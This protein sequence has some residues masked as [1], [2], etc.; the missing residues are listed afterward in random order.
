M[1][2]QRG[3]ARRMVIGLP[4][5]GLPPAWEKDFAAYVP[6]GVIVFRRDFRD[7]DGLRRLTSRLRELARPRRIFIAIDEEGGCVSQL[8]GH[9]VV[10]PNA[11]TLARGAE[12]EEITELHRVT[13]LRL[14]SLG[15]DWCFAPVADVN[16][17]PRN[18]VIGARSFGASAQAA[19]RGAGAAL[20]GL[21]A[22]GVAACLKHFPGHGDTRVDSHLALPRCEADRATLESRELA[23]FAALRDAP[24]VM[25]AHVVYPALDER[26]PATFSPAIV[27]DLLRSRLGFEGVCITDALEMKGAA[28]GRS[29]AEAARLA[30]E[31]G[32]DL[33]L[34]AFHSEEL[35]R[36]RLELARALVE[37]GLERAPG[38]D[39]ARPRLARLDA[40]HPEP[41]AAD[42]A[43]PL[44]EL[45]PAGWEARLERLI[46]RALEVRGALPA[47]AAGRPW[48]V[49][50]PEYPRGDSLASRLAAEGV[51]VAPGDGAASGPA[52]G[53]AA[54]LSVFVIA[55]R[56]PP[57]AD[58]IARIRDAARAGSC[59]VIGLQNDA[60]LDEIPEAALRVSASD[61]TALT[62]AVV[63]RRLAA[64]ARAGATA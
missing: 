19:T 22:G 9:L 44:A 31:A 24:A 58:K 50:E 46:E 51:A 40:L 1:D 20:R 63:A 37:G 42:L 59:A 23:P 57:P 60:F 49:I 12:P 47:V 14:K 6:A 35:R 43:R 8:D 28:E 53:G 36:V 11:V 62:R 2:A 45:T 39:A 64:L 13:A 18:P 26:R 17:E 54:S 52:V 3:I 16:C 25:T 21:G 10:P 30:L 33:L 41:G 5:D 32:C 27:T 15:L 7:L 56:V 4:P 38:F 29:P 48:R 61:S 55:S 34:F